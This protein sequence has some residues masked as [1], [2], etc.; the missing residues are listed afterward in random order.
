M[1]VKK[2]ISACTAVVIAM[3]MRVT[4]AAVDGGETTAMPAA[5]EVRTN[6][7]DTSRQL[8]MLARVAEIAAKGKS[9]PVRVAVCAV[10][11][12]RLNDAKFPNTQGEVIMQF[13]AMRDV[14]A[15]RTSAEYATLTPD[16]RSLR[17]A[18]AALRGGD[19]TRGALYFTNSE[20][21]PPE[22]RESGKILFEYDG[23]AFWR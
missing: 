23:M 13:I 21:V 12:N 11:L 10:L 7:I 4:T 18:A 19:P 20:S 1:T 9:F 2:I 16:D 15:P 3:T 6:D 22:I 14:F 8:E 5:T 17:A